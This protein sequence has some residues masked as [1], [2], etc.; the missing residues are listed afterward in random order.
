MVVAAEGGEVVGGGLPL[1]SLCLSL[2]LSLC[3]PPSA[4]HF[5][6]LLRGTLSPEEKPWVGV[7]NFW[8]MNTSLTHSSFIWL[9]N[10]DSLSL[11]HSVSLSISHLLPLWTSS[12]LF[13]AS[14]P[15]SRQ[16]LH[17]LIGLCWTLALCCISYDHLGDSLTQTSC[18][19]QLCNIVWTLVSVRAASLLQVF[20]LFLQVYC[21]AEFINYLESLLLLE[22]EVCV[23]TGSAEHQI[24]TAA[25]IVFTTWPESTSGSGSHQSQLRLSHPEKNKAAS[26]I[27]Y[28]HR[29][30]ILGLA[31]VPHSMPS[32]LSSLPSPLPSFPLPPWARLREMIKTSKA[33]P[34]CRS[35]LRAESMIPHRLPLHPH[36]RRFA[37]P[38]SSP[39]LLH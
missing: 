31:P 16:W 27:L 9:F 13:L 30:H 4:H 18:E 33:A 29:A 12:S 19:V 28:P 17:D 14:A 8:W 23:S 34:H 25:M 35:K 24:R 37:I 3:V 10:L 32:R 26:R 22:S 20:F 1:H 36:S 7:C 6:R 15:R 11:S 39:A 2:S 21:V 5:I 38:S